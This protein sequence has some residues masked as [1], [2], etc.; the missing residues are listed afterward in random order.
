MS[1]HLLS[2]ETETTTNYFFRTWYRLIDRDPGFGDFWHK[3]ATRAFYE[4]KVVLEAQQ[5]NIGSGD[6]YDHPVVSYPSDQLAIQGRR[7]LERMATAEHRDA[8]A[9]HT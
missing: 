1:T 9:E 7:I 4:D 3:T 8:V 6:L 2:P 5:E